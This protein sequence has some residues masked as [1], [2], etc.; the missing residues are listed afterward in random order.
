MSQTPL[1]PPLPPQFPPTEGHDLGLEPTR[2]S[3]PKVIGVL[4]IVW[5]SLWLFCNGC[6]LI[7][8]VFQSAMMKM[9][10][11]PTGPNAQQI[12]PMPDVMKPTVLDIAGMSAGMIL[13]VVLIVAGAMLVARNPK[14][15]VT[16]LVYAALS[17]LATLIGT[18]FAFQKQA[19]I[20]AWAKQNPD[21]FWGKSQS[22]GG[23]L[24]FIFI[25]VAVLLAMAYP[26][27]LLIWFLAVKRD[28]REITQGSEEPIV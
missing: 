8:Q 26:L 24:A 14:G 5:G 16:H 12:P 10:P 9:I 15:R 2:K 1:P 22:H 6:G 27:F 3:W 28:T 13:C 7:G 23:G 11:Q 18:T 21:N 19:A 17:I 20:Q 4:S 25:G